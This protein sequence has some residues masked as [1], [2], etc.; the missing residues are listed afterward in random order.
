MSSNI[1]PSYPAAQTPT[2]QS[3]RDNFTAAKSEIEAL[4]TATANIAVTTSPL[5][6]FASTTSAQL[7]GVISDETGSGS[8]VFGTSPTL[9]SP[10][11]NG[12]IA[13]SGL[14]MPAFTLGGTVS[15]GGNQ[16]NNVVIGASTPL[17]GSFTT[18]SA[19]G[20]ASFGTTNKL[21][22]LE[23]GAT[24]YF[25]TASNGVGQGVFANA[26][27]AGFVVGGSGIVTATATGLAVTGTLSSTG[28]ATVGNAPAAT[29]VALNINGV[30]NKAAKIAFQQSGVDK[31][32]IGN[33]AAS[34]N[35]NF[36]LYNAAGVVMLSANSAGTAITLGSGVN[37]VMASGQGIDFS[38][39]SN[40]SGTTTSE[41]LS[42]YEEGTWTPSVGGTATY[43]T[44]TGRYTKVGN[45]VHVEGVL[46]VNAI[47]TGSVDTI[48]GLPFTSAAS[49]KGLSVG[50]FFASATSV[51]SLLPTIPSSAA[52]IAVRALTAGA[53]TESSI[54]F[55][56]NNT[57]I[58]FSGTYNV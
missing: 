10:T 50:S 52:T 47:G 3:V 6:Q 38:A 19:T 26:T 34:E 53:T 56:Q 43:F 23:S 8:L 31:W 11:I 5:S 15:G 20:L 51:I 2:T 55:F 4:Q 14:T 46:V 33:G 7:A 54:T 16:L 39:T 29:N 30:V 40:G 9:A 37:L 21:Y 18:L 13:T 57:Q 41:V 25:T 35:N 49:V 44:Q 27:Q 36:E 48:S 22:A 12:T 17:A 42:D 58:Q 32:L 1:N 28:N 24:N 45:L